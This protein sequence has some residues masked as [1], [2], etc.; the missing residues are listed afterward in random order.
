M[1]NEA[2]TVREASLHGVRNKNELRVIAMLPA[3]LDEYPEYQPTALEIQDIYAL[4]LNL[5]PARYAQSYSFVIREPVTDDQ[6]LSTLHRAVKRVRD[7]PKTDE[8]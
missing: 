2:Y 6:I 5:L 3:I 4:A 7:H 1:P 8:Y